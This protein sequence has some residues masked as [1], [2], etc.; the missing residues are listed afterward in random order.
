MLAWSAKLD[1][2]ANGALSCMFYFYI[3]VFLYFLSLDRFF[4]FLAVNDFFHKP[5]E[6]FGNIFK[7]NFTPNFNI[8]FSLPL[9][10]FWL[11]V[12]IT[13]IILSFISHLAAS[14]KLNNYRYISYLLLIIFGAA[15]NLYD[16][17][18]YGFVI[19]YFDLKYFTV[20]NIAD[21]M[22]FFGVLGIIVI[23]SKKNEIYSSKN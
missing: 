4:K 12:I 7:L 14:L 9:S 21:A 23:L 11:N 6:I 3:F 16:R 1:Y 2:K 18:S 22:I 15:S 10:G 19:D 8:A 13:L 20:F 5:L 17:L